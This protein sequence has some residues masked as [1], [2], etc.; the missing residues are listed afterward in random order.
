MIK[1]YDDAI[2]YSC[3][4]F[5]NIIISDVIDNFIEI[6]SNMEFEFI[7]GSV[8]PIHIVRDEDKCMNVIRELSMYSKDDF[9]HILKP[10]HQYV[11]Y[12]I[13]EFS[14]EST[15]DE[16]NLVEIVKEYKERHKY[17]TNSFT[18]TEENLVDKIKNPDIFK[19]ICFEDYDFSE[20]FIDNMLEF[21]KRDILDGTNYLSYLN[22]DIEYIDEYLDLMPHDKQ[23]ELLKLKE[24]LKEKSI[25]DIKSYEEFESIIDNIIKDIKFYTEQRGLHKT[26]RKEKI[27]EDDFQKI[28]YIIINEK[29]RA[30]DLD[31][32]CEADS[33]RG[34]IDFKVSKGREYRCLIE[35][36]L[37]KNGCFE[38]NFNFQLSTYLNS[39]DVY[40][41]VFLLFIHNDLTYGKIESYIERAYE[42]SKEYNKLIK[43][44]YIDL[45]VKKS[46][47]KI[48]SREEQ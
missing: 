19:D 16:F 10:L 1:I 44:K 20:K 32:S 42:L 9:T 3:S 27:I 21:L 18:Y 4:K 28:F 38:S 29:C 34:R 11:L 37:D 40:M 36:K 24:I 30:Y 43:F 45:R 35:F 48:K 47:S 7:Y 41:G 26:L 17:L 6:G 22:I 33:G 39:E 15:D 12:N 46:A 31:V 25:K 23:E 8:F 2:S 5:I 13:L 14:I